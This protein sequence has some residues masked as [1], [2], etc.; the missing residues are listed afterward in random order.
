MSARAGVMLTHPCDATA[1]QVRELRRMVRDPERNMAALPHLYEG[2]DGSWQSQAPVGAEFEPWASDIVRWACRQPGAPGDE[3]RALKQ[4]VRDAPGVLGIG[5]F[6]RVRRVQ[7]AERAGGGL[8][9][10]PDAAGA[11]GGDTLALKEQCL[12]GGVSARVVPVREVLVGRELGCAEPRHP[13]AAYVLPPTLVAVGVPRGGGGKRLLLSATRVLPATL[14][15]LAVA[16]GADLGAL[17]VHVAKVAALLADLQRAHG[18]VHGDLWSANVMVDGRGCPAVIDLGAAKVGGAGTL[19]GDVP[20]QGMD[21]LALSVDLHERLGAERSAR[22]FGDS[23]AGSVQRAAAHFGTLMQGVSER[24]ALWHGALG[25]HGQV[26]ASVA[27]PFVPGRYLAALAPA[28]GMD[29]RAVGGGAVDLTPLPA[30]RAAPLPAARAAPLPAARG[31]ARAA[32]LPAPAAPLPARAAPLPAPA[33]PAAMAPSSDD[34]FAVL[35]DPDASLGMLG[36]DDDG[37]GDAFGDVFGDDDGDGG[38]FGDVFGDDDGDDD[39]GALPVVPDVDVGAMVDIAHPDE[40]EMCER[41]RVAP[42]KAPG[43]DDGAIAAARKAISLDDWGQTAGFTSAFCVSSEGGI[44]AAYNAGDTIIYADSLVSRRD[45]RRRDRLV[46]APTVIDSRVDGWCGD[47]ACNHLRVPGQAHGAWDAGAATAAGEARWSVLTGTLRRWKSLQSRRHRLLAVPVSFNH[48]S[49]AK[50]FRELRQRQYGAILFTVAPGPVDAPVNEKHVYVLQSFTAAAV[51][52]ARVAADGDGGGDAGGLGGAPEGFAPGTTVKGSLP[53]E[54]RLEL[55]EAPA[56]PLRAGQ[57][58]VV[59]KGKEDKQRAL[60]DAFRAFQRSLWRPP[61]GQG[62]AERA[63]SAHVRRLWAAHKATISSL[64][65]Q[66]L[67]ALNTSQGGR[68]LPPGA[69]AAALAASMLR[70]GSAPMSDAAVAS[71]MARIDA[72]IAVFRAA[73]VAAAKAQGV[74]AEGKDKTRLTNLATAYEGP[75]PSAG[76]KNRNCDAATRDDADAAVQGAE[77]PSKLVASPYA[78]LQQARLRLVELQWVL[79]LVPSG[80]VSPADHWPVGF[81]PGTAARAPR[82][83]ADYVAER[84]SGGAGATEAAG[85][86]ATVRV[87]IEEALARVREQLTVADGRPTARGG[88]K[89]VCRA[90]QGSAEQSLET[91]GIPGTSASM[92]RYV[93][94]RVAIEL[95][96]FALAADGGTDAQVVAYARDRLIYDLERAQIDAES[97]SLDGDRAAPAARRGARASERAG[98][99]QLR[100]MFENLWHGVAPDVGGDGWEVGSWMWTPLLGAALVKAGADAQLDGRVRK[101][102]FWTPPLAFTLGAAGV[103][104]DGWSTSISDALAATGDTQAA[105]GIFKDP[106]S[107]APGGGTRSNLRLDD[108]QQILQGAGVL[109][110][111]PGGMYRPAAAA[112]PWFARAAE[113]ARSR[114]L[115]SA[116]EPRLTRELLQEFAGRADAHDPAMFQAAGDKATARALAGR[117]R[118]AGGDG[119]DR[120]VEYLAGLLKQYAAFLRRR[121]DSPEDPSDLAVHPETLFLG[122]MQDGAIGACRRRALTIDAVFGIAPGGCA[123]GAGLDELTEMLEHASGA[124]AD[125][126]EYTRQLTPAPLCAVADDRARANA[127]ADI[128]YKWQ[129]PH[130]LDNATKLTLRR[131]KEDASALLAGGRADMRALVQAARVALAIPPARPGRLEATFT[132]STGVYMD[133]VAADYDFA[134]AAGARVAV[135]YQIEEDTF[136]TGTGPDFSALDSPER[137]LQTLGDVAQK[138]LRLV[139]TVREAR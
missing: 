57:T 48:N 99:V 9:L 71:E 82:A 45:W 76:C 101:G 93:W 81:A 94:R 19:E 13:H 58:F 54:R 92:L 91:W 109:E 122:N 55:S 44:T 68:P 3:R 80:S 106:A 32:P 127:V 5:T 119:S 17:R 33:A 132:D 124:G 65:A 74:G 20:R 129:G 100:A 36:D 51:R 126:L 25:I 59:A 98:A 103:A 4:R 63:A 108:V 18:F 24:T 22:L 34:A 130:G 12:T 46:A 29:A 73:I 85:C 62:G 135:H 52:G 69:D 125:V 118:G 123:G 42:R 104:Y 77:D 113:L 136:V 114:L 11:A 70:R 111:A 110:A 116:T 138:T 112:A 14:R 21:L 120:A 117:L 133:N 90:A 15:E 64:G 75:A 35:D 66:A 49:T 47:D 134:L 43:L 8:A 97:R 67:R 84:G 137:L 2:P 87:R 115:G 40:G 121:D 26:S 89:V 96:A 83:G 60:S 107:H 39:G 139:L 53:A 102:E 23:L 38:A 105:T 128:L 50:G 31:A 37:D 7:R 28:L 88:V 131:G 16:E 86:P 27:A 95:G 41:A 56:H 79:M 10:L 61:T 6:G 1:S 72:A 30:A 78:L